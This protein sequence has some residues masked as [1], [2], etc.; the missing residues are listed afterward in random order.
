M[1]RATKRTGQS[2]D[3]CK[4]PKIESAVQEANKE[5]CGAYRGYKVHRGDAV[6]EIGE[7]GIARARFFSRYVRPRRPAKFRTMNGLQDIFGGRFSPSNLEQTLT[8]EGPLTVERKHKGGF[9]SGQRRERMLLAELMARFRAGDD[10]YYLTTQYD[11]EEYESESES[12]SDNDDDCEEAEV[13]KAPIDTSSSADGAEPAWPALESDDESLNLA[14]IHDDFDDVVSLEEEI[15]M[16]SARRVRELFQPPLWAIRDQIPPVPPFLAGLVPQQVNLWVGYSKENAVPS[17]I[18]DP[19]SRYVPGGANSSGLHHDHAD[20]LYLLLNGRKRFTLY[21]P[22]DAHKL[23]TV[24]TIRKIYNSGVIDYE[25]DDNAPSW[26]HVRDDGA[27]I[28]EVAR[29]RLGQGDLEPATRAELEAVLEHEENGHRHRDSTRSTNRDNANLEKTPPSFSRIPPALLHLDEL[30]PDL[31]KELEEF[32]NTHF[33]GFLQLNK[34]TVWL[35]AGEMLYLPTGWFHEVSSFA[36]ETVRSNEDR[37]HIAVNYWFAPPNGSS[38][39]KLYADTYWMED[40]ELTKR[41]IAAQNEQGTHLDA[42][43]GPLA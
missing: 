37:I 30:T 38:P 31:R 42:Y 10:S 23:Y 5:S 20:N 3:A 24:G 4:R 14:N 33:P 19:D 34:L 32:S 1:D 36:N 12:E 21:S 26:D 15:D 6:E 39:E 2:L 11:E 9:G 18:L 13:L 27:L 25:A 40:F 17:D 29:W 16:E 35:S 7:Q 22:A 41:A 28:R 8:Y 43:H